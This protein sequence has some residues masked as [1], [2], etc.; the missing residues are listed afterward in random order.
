[1]PYALVRCA[2]KPAV[3]RARPQWIP[4]MAWS[5][6]TGDADQAHLSPPA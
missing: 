5:F 6:E 3:S 4:A 1:M 2:S